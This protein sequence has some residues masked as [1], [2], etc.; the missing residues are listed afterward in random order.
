MSGE[1]LFCREQTQPEIIQ[2]MEDRANRIF[3]LDSYIDENQLCVEIAK[4][5][6]LLN[7]KGQGTPESDL[8]P[9]YLYIYCYGGDFDQALMLCDVIESSRIP[10]YTVALGPTMSSG[11]VVFLAGHKRYVYP[12]ATLMLHYGKCKFDGDYEDF[13]EERKKKI[14]QQ[15][16]RS[17]NNM[18]EYL[19]K[20]ITIEPDVLDAK[21][22]DE[23]YISK[24]EM[25]SYGIVDKIVTSDTIL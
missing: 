1:E 9:I 5:I 6:I 14:K 12:H 17:M 3:Y 20:K 2:Y 7:R 24:E 10:V 15:Y 18:K 11:C 21:L 19:R 23:W 16:N 8:K 25:S 22:Q 13:N 4:N